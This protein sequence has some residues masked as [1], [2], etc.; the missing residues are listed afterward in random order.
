MRPEKAHRVIQKAIDAWL[1][2]DRM[3]L[4]ESVPAMEKLLKKC[5]K[6]E[7]D[8]RSGLETYGY[9]KDSNANNMMYISDRWRCS[10]RLRWLIDGVKGGYL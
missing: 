7:D 1:G 5:Q 2:G 6:E 4:K 3:L 9:N 10:F 8:Y